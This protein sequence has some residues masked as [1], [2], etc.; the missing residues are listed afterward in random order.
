M[1]AKR[2]APV[3]VSWGFF[4]CDV[5][6]TYGTIFLCVF[7]D[8]PPPLYIQGFAGIQYCMIP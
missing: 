6:F 5:K 8:V 7:T 3:L 4:I 2:K 1:A